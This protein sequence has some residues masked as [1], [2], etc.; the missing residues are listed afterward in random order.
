M[1][2]TAF[3]RPGE[4]AAAFFGEN[5]KAHRH[6]LYRWIESGNLACVRIGERRDRWIPRSEL[7]RLRAEAESN[8]TVATAGV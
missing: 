8:R 3:L 1:T 2:D 5:S 7:E 6:V 4:F